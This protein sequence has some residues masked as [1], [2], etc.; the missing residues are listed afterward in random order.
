MP[1]K[2]MP[3]PRGLKFNAAHLPKVSNIGL[4]IK[5]LINQSTSINFLVHLVGDLEDATEY[6]HRKV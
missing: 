3:P 4:K 2:A 1:L 5:H 6:Y